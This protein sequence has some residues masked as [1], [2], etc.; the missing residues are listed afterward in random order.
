MDEEITL[1][2]PRATF[3]TAREFVTLFK[4]V[5]DAADARIKAEEKTMASSQKFGEFMQPAPEQ[6]QPGLEGFEQ[7]LAAMSN[8]GLGL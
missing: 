2:L 7:E 3:E 4:Q 1:S 5:L 6:G 8:R